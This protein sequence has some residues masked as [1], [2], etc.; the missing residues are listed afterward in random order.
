MSKPSG[1]GRGLSALL[2]EANKGGRRPSGSSGAAIEKLSIS[3]IKPNPDQ[4]RRRF[5]KEALDELAQ[6]I[7]K[8]GVLQPILVRPSGPIFEIIA[9][10][11]RWRAAQIA[12]IH[13]IPAIVRELDD[14]S[15]A[16]IALIENV[17]RED[18]N[19]LEEAAAY[20]ALAEKFG[21]D[22]ATIGEMVGKSRSHVANLIRLLDLPEE[23]KQ[24][25]LRGDISMG[26]ARA[27]L[28]AD[29]PVALA[30]QVVSENLNVR[31]A[32]DRAKSGSSAPRSQRPGGGPSK[33]ADIEALESQLSDM[34]GL[35]VA[36]SH[37]DKGGKVQL[38]YRTL[39]QLDMICQRLSG[40][41]I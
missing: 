30:R 11:R 10:E 39:D 34:L 32:E 36:V 38:R 37:G 18:L 33:Q 25:L 19:A 13:E 22:Q 26:H 5:D 4:P 41:P 1:L 2:D 23:V 21:H 40:E 6:S 7:S 12:Q 24:M 16:E 17:Q 14:E 29:D 31:E 8:Q 3:D 20:R 35:K 15:T 28:G 27:A 9:G